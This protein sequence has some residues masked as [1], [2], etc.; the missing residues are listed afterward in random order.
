MLLV[1]SVSI[2]TLGSGMAQVALA[3]AVLD[4]GTITD[5]GVVLLA[6]EAALIVFLL[7]GGVWADRVSRQRLLVA[8][9]VIRAAT[10]AL[11]AWLLISGSAAVWSLA[12]LQITYG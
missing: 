7:L 12:L 6:R 8:G 11:G 2:S 4:V 9:D 1:A 5:L 3:F 10:Q